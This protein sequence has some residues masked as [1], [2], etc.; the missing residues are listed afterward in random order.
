GKPRFWVKHGRSVTRGEGLTQAHVAKIVN[1][2]HVRVVR[3]PEVYLI[4]SR[5]T[6]A[7]IVMELAGGMTFAKRKLDKG[8]YGEDNMKA[9]KMPVDTSPGYI[10]GGRIGHDFFVEC[11]SK[12]EYHT[13]GDLEEHINRVLILAETKSSVNFQSEITDGLVLCPSD[14]DDTNIMVDNTGTIWA[15]DFGR[16]CFLPSSFMDYSS[17]SSSKPFGQRMAGLVDYPKS[18]NYPA[19]ETAAGQLVLHNNSFAKSPLSILFRYAAL[20][21]N[22]IG[23]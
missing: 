11:L 4:F 21:T 12:L 2:D 13:V 10:G 7:Y 5:G 16:T 14:L 19:M 9:I 23:T 1:A 17:R 15:I 6:W 22:C 18:D 20:V 8:N 3:V